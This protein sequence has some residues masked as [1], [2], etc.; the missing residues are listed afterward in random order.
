MTLISPGAWLH[1]AIWHV[2]LE[3][4]HWIHQVACNVIRIGWHWIC[5]VAAP[6]IVTR[7]YGI[8]TLNLPGGSTLQCGRW[9][10][11]DM[12]WN[13]PKRPSYC[14]STSGFNFDH[15]TAVDMLFCTSLRNFIQI[16]PPSA[17]KIDVMS[18]FKMADLRHL[19]F[20]GSNNGFFEKPMYDLGRQ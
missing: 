8:M 15:I 3:S 5:P 20:Y 9:L 14:N 2:A 6:C 4:W 13:S 19:G 18:I 1:P 7:S 10:W 17:E 11:D 12:P 16:G